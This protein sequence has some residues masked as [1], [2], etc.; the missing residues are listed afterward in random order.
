VHLKGPKS[1]N[2]PLISLNNIKVQNVN[3]VANAVVTVA[4]DHSDSIKDLKISISEY[5]DSTW[6]L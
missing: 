5:D 6:V 1:C 2:I 4:E 3:G